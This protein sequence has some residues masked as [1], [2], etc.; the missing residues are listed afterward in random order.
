MRNSRLFCILLCIFINFSAAQMIQPG[1]SQKE[2]PAKP[3]NTEIEN[4]INK[5][6]A[7]RRK[8]PNEKSLDYNL[9]NLNYLK[10]DY[11]KAQKE[12]GNSLNQVDPVKRSQ[13]LYNLGNTLV[14]KG[15][16]QDGIGFYKKALELNPVDS[17]IKYNYELSQMLL[18]QQQQQQQQQ[19]DD[20]KQDQK[21][22]Q[23][24]QQ[25]QQDQQQQTQN[26]QDQQDQQQQDKKEDDKEAQQE[27]DQQQPDE[28]KQD[29]EED[30]KQPTQADQ[31]QQK[32]LD[33]Q[34]AEAI[35]NTLKANEENM[36]KKK[37]RAKGHVKVD[38]DW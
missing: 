17:D 6:E 16:I 30:K 5:Y 13:A 28:A 4:A 26:D 21:R 2:A 23:D 8:Y 7:L 35:L 25:Q 9:G 14:K 31:D 11:E 38:Q 3:P 1:P 34:E 37:Y 29:Q 32:E 18:K 33:K 15:S 27:K 36:L 20:N 19:G 10:G 24:Q 12:Y 22:D